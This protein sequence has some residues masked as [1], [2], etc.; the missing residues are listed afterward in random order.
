MLKKLMKHEFRA[1]GRIMLPLFAAV[2]IA[3]VGANFSVRGLLETENR[4]L[5]VFGT[6]LMTVFGVAI[7]AVCI[8]AFGLMIYRFYKNLLRDEGYVML[9][10][11]VSLH[12]HI[13]SKL[14]VSIIWYAGTAV[15]I[16]LAVMVLSIGTGFLSGI[17]E[18]LPRI[19]ADLRTDP[20]A[21]HIVPI[22]L[23]I[24]LLVFF[25]VA[26]TCMEL[27]AAMAIGHSFPNHKLLLSAVVFLGIRFVIQL[28]SGVLT[29]VFGFSGFISSVA[30]WVSNWPE[31]AIAHAVLI[32]LTVFSL[33]FSG[34]FYF[35]T[36]YFMGK[37]LNL[38]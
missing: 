1:T 3:S 31:I 26:S 22:S 33:I 23:E 12:Q 17:G 2:L 5:N 27:Y 14:L 7:A 38:E 11:P 24:L 34:A 13:W 32:G 20:L 21:A 28:V 30:D 36:V 16:V 18:E 6:V 35:L 25:G 8:V 37:R 29:V 19:F 4:I 15:C 10:L 9:T